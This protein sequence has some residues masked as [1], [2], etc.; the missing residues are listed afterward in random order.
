MI[1]NVR[2]AVFTSPWFKLEYLSIN[3][4]ISFSASPF[5]IVN[6]LA[7]EL[8]ISTHAQNLFTIFQHFSLQSRD[9]YGYC[10]IT[11]PWQTY[12][13]NQLFINCIEQNIKMFLDPAS[14]NWWCFI[15]TQ[16]I[17]GG[18]LALTATHR[19]NPVPVT[20]WPFGENKFVDVAFTFCIGMME[21]KCFTFCLKAWWI[22][23]KTEAQCSYRVTR[24]WNISKTAVKMM[25]NFDSEDDNISRASSNRWSV[26]AFEL[27]GSDILKTGYLKKLKV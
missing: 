20:P 16:H 13:I 26:M 7:N 10:I 27:P 15:Y 8:S 6:K 2:T 19:I 9:R 24:S 4:H 17:A 25:E 23:F 1:A 21:T 22:F 18:D 5:F 11:C 3:F 14:W 12:E